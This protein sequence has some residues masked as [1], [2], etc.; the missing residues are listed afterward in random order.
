MQ[1]PTL[2]HADHRD[3]RECRCT[4]GLVCARCFA[5]VS[6]AAAEEDLQRWLRAFGTAPDPGAPKRGC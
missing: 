1:T 2:D 4:P 5:V 6:K 3:P